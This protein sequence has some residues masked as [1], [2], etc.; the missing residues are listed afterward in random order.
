MPHRRGLGDQAIDQKAESELGRLLLRG[1]LDGIDVP[2]EVLAAAGGEY[3]RLW[4][5]YLATLG[6]PRALYVGS[7]RAFVCCGNVSI[8]NRRECVCLVRQRA[9][10]E[11]ML[12]LRK[13][14]DG[15]L[16]AVSLVCLHDRPGNVGALRVGLVALAGYFGLGS[17]LTGSGKSLYGKSSSR[18][19]V[20]PS[21]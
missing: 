2:A 11:A 6:G 17:R 10:L 21:D 1:A 18:C 15:V 19:L 5:G 9:W 13:E 20:T 14:G 8:L 7:G 12:R 16:R 4:R 3:A